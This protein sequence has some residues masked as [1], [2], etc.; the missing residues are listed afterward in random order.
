[1]KWIVNVTLIGS[2]NDCLF[3]EISRAP[4][5]GVAAS[6]S[7]EEG[8][9]SVLETFCHPSWSKNNELCNIFWMIQSLFAGKNVGSQENKEFCNALLCMMVH[10][11]A[12]PYSFPLNPWSFHV[13]SQ[14]DREYIM[15]PPEDQLYVSEY[16]GNAHQSFETPAPP[17]HAFGLERGIHFLCKWK[18]L[19]STVLED[20]SA[21]CIPL[22]LL[23]NT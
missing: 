7:V 1:M 6:I 19:K 2:F 3:R 17:S 13:F 14:E 9:S 21:W 4:A 10:F 15:E 18:W 11:Q 23:F 5:Q 12:L 20:K 8:S 22:P 16:G